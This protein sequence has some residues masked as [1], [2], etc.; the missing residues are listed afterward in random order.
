MSLVFKQFEW[1]LADLNV[2]CNGL[3]LLRGKPDLYNKSVK[4]F[5][6]SLNIVTHK[7]FYTESQNKPSPVQVVLV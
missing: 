6:I 2:N 4:L 5:K 1:L 7:E 3:L